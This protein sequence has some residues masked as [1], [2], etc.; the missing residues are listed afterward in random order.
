[1]PSLVDVASDT[2]PTPDGA[3]DSS[4]DAGPPCDE[5]GLVAHWRMQ[6]G[7]GLL[8]HDCS[9]G[10]HHGA[11]VNGPAWVDGRPGRKAI[12]FDPNVTGMRIEVGDAGG[13]AAAFDITGALTL[14]A[15]IHAYGAA[16]S[17]RVISKTASADRGWDFDLQPDASIEFRI[18][19]TPD[20]YAWT[21]YDSLSLGEWKYVAAVYDPGSTLTVYIDGASVTELNTGVPMLQRSS[22]AGVMIGARS[23]GYTFEGMLDDVRVYSRVLSASEILALFNAK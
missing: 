15:W 12:K 22:E 21:S 14:T 6:E 3:I 2:T 18:G 17:G 13:N 8:V 16:G 20:A 10:G 5:P 9:S 11:L 23:D 19:L 4:Y 1:V 7:A